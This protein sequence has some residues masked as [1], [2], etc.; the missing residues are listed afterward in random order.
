MDL[1]SESAYRDPSTTQ[2]PALGSGKCSA[3]A[4]RLEHY[5]LVPV[6]QDPIFHVGTHRP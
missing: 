2:L 6:D 5:G 1:R 3:Q 4:D